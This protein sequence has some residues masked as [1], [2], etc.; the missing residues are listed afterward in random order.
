MMD[1]Q[2]ILKQLEG[3]FA[4]NTLRAYRADFNDFSQWCVSQQLTPG[5]ITSD[6]IANYIAW[7]VPNRSSATIRRRIATLSSLYKLM[8]MHDPT[9][10]APVVIA[11]KRM[12][13]QKGRAQKQALPLTNDILQQLLGVCA[14]D[15]AGQ[16]NR[17][18]LH[19]G[20]ETMRRRA[21]LCRFCFED[22]QTLA[23]G[24]VVLNLRFSKT[25]QYGEGRLIAITPML[26]ELIQKWG[27][28]IGR[29]GY[30]LRGVYKG[31]LSVG[32]SLTPAS[33]NQILA[34]LQNQAG[35]KLERNLSG[36]SFRVGAAVD[37]LLAGETMERIMLKGGWKSE[38]TVMRYLRAMV[39]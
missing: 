32:E 19:L 16:R 18:L 4:K 9:R 30:I 34:K 27:E 29:K 25:D 21:E 22:L 2:Q 11:L 33:I 5:H 3:A 37:M 31:K 20:H 8:D 23:T 13:R 1:V 15:L 17:V 7:M 35:L 10:A 36:H 39:L 28:T 12:H 14:N 24:Q 38:S 26:T 6:E